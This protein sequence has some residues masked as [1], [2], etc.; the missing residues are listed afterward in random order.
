[1]LNLLLQP[2][3][4]LMNRLAYFSKFSLVAILF[5]LP[6]LLLSSI[7]I[8]QLWSDLRQIQRE[9]AGLELQGL[10]LDLAAAAE[11]Y[12]DLASLLETRDLP[13]V[14]ERS[15]EAKTHWLNIH[16]QLVELSSELLAAS[17]LNANLNVLRE[18]A[19]T[20]FNE[21]PR[22]GNFSLALAHY[23]PLV[24]SS[25]RV[26]QEIRQS[27]DL[28]RDSRTEIQLLQMLLTTELPLLLE[29]VGTGRSYGNL[30]L[31]QE[32]MD[33][34][35]STELEGVLD[36]LG[37]QDENWQSLLDSLAFRAPEL[38][39]RL[40]VLG[41]EV[42]QGLLD[43]QEVL[44]D[45]V[46]FAIGLDEPWEEFYEESQQVRD[47]LVSVGN[48]L[49][50][51]ADQI[52]ASAE[53]GQ[54]R[55]LFLMGSLL[56]FQLLIIA[57]LYTCFYVS[58][59]SNM[60][61][62]LK[63]VRSFAEGD[64]R[65]TPQASTKDEMGTLTEAFAQMSQRMRELV[66]MVGASAEQVS[67]QAGQV[68]SNA[69]TARSTS[70]QQ[71]A[72]TE[73]VAT[74]MNEMT[75]TATEVAEHAVSAATTAATAREK[76]EQGQQVVG[77]MRDR[78]QRLAL[79]LQDAGE[80]GHS[81]VER[82]S[83]IGEA[84]E[85]IR[86]IAEQTNLLALNAAIEAARAGDAGRG[87]AVVADEVRSLASRTQNSTHEIAEIIADLHQG[88]DGVVSHIDKSRE[89]AEQTAEQSEQVDAS[90]AAILEGVTA[91]DSKSQQIAAAAEEQSAVASEID[92]NLERIRDGSDASAQG[93]QETAASSRALTATTEEL[94]E[95]ISVFKIS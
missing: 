23:Q 17:N 26:L 91:I 53:T 80:A 11:D 65:T 62:L 47:L 61:S 75:A 40:E 12:R 59:H 54:N 37:R 74:S 87:F 20:L 41:D 67:S 83:R 44:E 24:I 94:Q 5:L 9:R 3:M 95:A 15:D 30:A 32:Y 50:G 58:M 36:D 51:E 76:A 82:S 90:L 84:L 64:L 4:A 35:T 25:Q 81:L 69:D 13:E 31:L 16:E 1:M 68:S 78:M 22:L 66:S 7:Q 27:S 14:M 29:S 72:E 19:E 57:Y 63:S 71:Q 88:V 49:L 70:E 45:Q 48:R 92:A 60:R 39:E 6:M 10:T 46:V 89:R 42:S 56:T 55:N 38:A 2:G 34:R 21:D 8:Q 33:S 79:A 52:L 86:G 43:F 93:A 28:M 77:E 85:V 73:Q 18:Q